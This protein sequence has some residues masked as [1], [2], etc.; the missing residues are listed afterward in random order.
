MHIASKFWFCSESPRWRLKAGQSCPA[1]VF[2][3]VDV[4]ISSDDVNSI[5]LCVD[6]AM[7]TTF[8]VRSVYDAIDPPSNAAARAR[9]AVAAPPFDRVSYA[10][11]TMG[12]VCT[13]VSLVCASP[14][15]VSFSE[16]DMHRLRDTM[17]PRSYPKTG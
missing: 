9:G 13:V 4:F 5:G 3:L 14:S 8:L 12:V 7:C 2:F 16:I 17:Q 6:A 11:R 10:C 1:N 15:V